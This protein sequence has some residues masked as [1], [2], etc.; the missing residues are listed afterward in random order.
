MTTSSS[1]FHQNF[2]ILKADTPDLIDAAHELRYQ[3]YCQEKGYEDAERYPDRRE[4]DEYD[5]HAV[6]S[7]I[8]H[9]HS[10]V[11]I[12]VVRLVLP[13][14][15]GADRPLPIEQHCGLDLEKSHPHLAT[16]P[17]QAIGEIS[18]FSVSKVYRRRIAEQGLI[19]GVCREG[20]SYNANFH[21]HFN[22]RHLPLITL[23]LIAASL[24]MCEEYKIRHCY[25]AMEPTLLR[26][27]QGVGIGFQPLGMPVD[28]HGMR[29]PA[30]YPVSERMPWVLNTRSE[31]RGIYYGEQTQSQ[32]RYRHKQLVAV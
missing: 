3:V 32:A 8:R 11:Y 20:E 13:H 25:A 12:G 18:R 6:H 14:S 22:R 29:V 17:R 9:R 27:L 2:E 21:P 28:Y 26:L 30:Y 16:L 24:R 15:G 7:L 1:L 23:G 4:S 10:G 19:W 5:S 31:L